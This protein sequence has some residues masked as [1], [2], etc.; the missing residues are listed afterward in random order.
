MVQ[1]EQ[2][3]TE[4]IYSFLWARRKTH[5]LSVK[6]HYQVMQEVIPENIVR[7]TI[8][9][10][11]GCGCGYD[12]YVMANNRKVKIC[13]IDISDGVYVASSLNSLLSNVYILKGSALNIPFKDNTFD[14]SYSFGVLHHTINPE[15]G[16]R[17]MA[18]VIKKNSPVYLY[19]Y[20]DHSDNRLK[21]IAL[22]LITELRIMTT[23]MPPKILYIISFLISPFIVI[24][25]SYPAKILSKFKITR[26][27]SDKV[28]F[29]FGTNLFSLTGDI[30][31]RFGA[32]IEHRFNK[33]EIIDLFEQNGLTDV[34]TTKMKSIAGWVAW[35]YKK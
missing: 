29:N 15:R 23:K 24:F 17:E 7:G 32:P 27:L 5:K 31:D 10:D 11:V 33:K 19:L 12:T 30:Y 8:G 22:K 25:F 2:D 26:S 16:I 4:Q 20:E 35:G 6:S 18:R 13:G 34:R 14:F 9:I 21:Y 3:K 28:P 1:A